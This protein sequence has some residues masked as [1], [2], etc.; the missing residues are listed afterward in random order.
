M[1]LSSCDKEEWEKNEINSSGDINATEEGREK[2]LEQKLPCSPLD[3]SV[4][5]Q[6]VFLQPTELRGGAE[7]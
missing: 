5:R 7:T 2:A 6:A 3:R 1:V 4:V